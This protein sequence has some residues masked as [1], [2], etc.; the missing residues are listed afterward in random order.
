MF[1]SRYALAL[2]GLIWVAG[3]CAA[4]RAILYVTNSGGNDVTL[5]DVAANNTIGSIETG[6]TPHGLEASPDGTRVYISGETDDDIVAI[7]TATS[8]VLWKAKI[9]DRPNHIAVSAD[10]R[11]VYAPIRSADYADV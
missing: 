9:G 5:V 4:S 6:S 2:A 7:E 8:K 1:S 10:G 3:P 11:Y